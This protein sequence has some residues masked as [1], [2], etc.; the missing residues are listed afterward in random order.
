LTAYKQLLASELPHF[1][2]SL[3]G[4]QAM[5]EKERRREPR[6]K[7]RVQVAIGWGSNTLPAV[8]RDL[9]MDGMFIETPD[10]LWMHAEFTARLS[11]PEPIEVD[12]IVIRVEPGR[13]MGVEFKDLP[14]AEREQLD[15]FMSKL[16]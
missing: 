4:F 8:A 13:G 3:S 10:P 15:L 1:V 5:S 9:S 12:C 11:L 16:A 7:C 14:E 6:C 2:E